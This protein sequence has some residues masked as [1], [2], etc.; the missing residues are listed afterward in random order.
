MRS[1][2]FC[3]IIE[4]KEVIFLLKVVFYSR[5]STDEEKQLNAL[6]KQ[7]Q[8]LA[9]YI[10]SQKDWVLVD[11]YID[12]GISGTTSK[13]RHEYNRLYNDLLTDKFDIVVIKDQSRL[14]RNV[15]DW[16]LF[17]DRV[18][19]NGKQIFMYLDN[20][21]YT[22]D[23]AFISG[24]KAMMA[25]EYSRDLSRKIKSAAQRSQR[26]GTVYG[27]NRMLG[28][29]Q[30][31][32]KLT[33][34]EEEAEIVRK[35]FEWYIQGNGFRV[36]QQKLLDKGIMSTTGTPF[37]LSTLKR[38]IK[39][40]KYKGLL[41][42]GKRR[43][44]FE[45]KQ[46]VN[47]PESEWVVIPNG[48]PAIVSEEIWEK[49]N[50][51]LRE[52]CVENGIEYAKTRGTFKSNVY[53]LSGKIY[54]GKCGKP[55]W[56]EFYLTK[57]NKIPRN[58]WQCS[59]YKA[60][61]KRPDKGCQNKI[62]RDDIIMSKL[63][64]ILF[65]T[66]NTSS[67]RETLDILKLSLQGNNVNYQTTL[68]KIEKLTKR[69]DKLLEMLLDEVITKDEYTKKKNE[70]DLQ[71]ESNNKHYEELLER[72]K[73]QV[74]VEDRLNV[75]EQFLSSKFN[76]P[77]DIDDETVK[78]LVDKIIVTDDIID[79]YLK[80]GENTTVS[81]NNSVSN[82]QIKTSVCDRYCQVS[83]T[84]RNIYSQKVRRIK[85]RCPNSWLYFNVYV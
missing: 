50:Q 57:V 1:L 42:S 13:G 44:N 79:V 17:L 62:L 38:M 49:A 83:G 80:N 48:V 68:D 3:V 16:Y 36:I 58:T 75:I 10:H 25:E 27:N 22:P 70:L 24:I 28:Y 59:T 15:L 7:I 31:G 56:H 54:C 51:C 72:S 71:I 65:S 26:N 34:I 84:H 77:D 82:S 5:V 45:T 21:F 32:G 52:R 64:E 29:K 12:E 60:Y 43:K 19:K 81:I 76:S 11:K 46:M 2:S 61:G 39:Q 53:P 20:S 78:N 35:V 30:E 55:Y 74:S 18:M 41:I 67:V 85:K 6:D 33:I 23:N 9:D 40:E 63:K 66:Y 69:K 73:N 4:L 14:M 8:E 47:V 37:S